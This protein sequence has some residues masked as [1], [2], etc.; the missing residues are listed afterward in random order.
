MANPRHKLTEKQK[1]EIVSL[2]QIGWPPSK[3]AR[4]YGVSIP[5]VVYHTRNL[6]QFDARTVISLAHAA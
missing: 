1:L 5:A 6:P 3:I 4:E 2:W